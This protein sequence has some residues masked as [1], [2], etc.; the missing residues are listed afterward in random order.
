MGGT[1]CF[2]GLTNYVIKKRKEQKN[3]IN[4]KPILFS[5]L[6]TE[7]LDPFDNI[8]GKVNVF[9]V[10]S[11]IYRNKDIIWNPPFLCKQIYKSSVETTKENW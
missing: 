8:D 6:R 10:L 9:L 4:L 5:Y 11:L 3:V 2:A 1:G 7:N